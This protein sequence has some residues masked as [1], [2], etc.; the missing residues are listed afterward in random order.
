MLRGEP[1]SGEVLDVQ[2]RAN[3]AGRRRPGRGG[4]LQ[5]LQS[6]GDDDGEEKAS[7]TTAQTSTGETQTVTEN[8]PATPATQRIAVEAGSRWAVSP[9]R[10]P[11]RHGQ[12]IVSSPDTSGEVHLHGYDISRDMAPGARRDS[13]SRRRTRALR[14]S[15][16]T[17]TCRSRRSRCGLRDRRPG[18]RAR[19]RSPI[20]PADP[21]VAVRLG[22]GDGARGL[23]RRPGGALAGP[24][25][26][27]RRLAH[28]RAP[29]RP[30]ATSGPAE[31]VCGGVFLLGLVVYSG[32]EGT[33][34][35]HNFAPTFV[36]V[37]F[38][39]GLVAASVLSATSS[40]P[41]I[42]GTRSARVM[43]RPDGRA[44]ADAGAA[45][46][47]GTAGALAGRGGDLRLCGP[48]ARDLGG[49]QAGERGDR[50]ARTR[51]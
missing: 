51:R 14:S 20:G 27:G 10:R 1:F 8:A 15:S 49:Q 45:R 35:S 30:R 13:S 18:D 9:G 32:L 3:R 37:T 38:W 29:A 17:R 24:A 26:A 7:T 25:A 22:R 31:I 41:S 43:G 50:G 2:K 21:R 19:A 48:R 33:L 6:S 39:V 23:V 47:P 44:G 40:A 34:H 12:L 11:G 36:Y 42:P 16:R 4:G 5:S 46:V 28:G